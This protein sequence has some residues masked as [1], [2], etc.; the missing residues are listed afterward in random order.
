[1]IASLPGILGDPE[2]R[3]YT[4]AA[5]IQNKGV[6]L[7]LNWADNINKDWGYNLNGNIAFNHNEVLELNEGEPLP[8]GSVGGQ[9]TTTLTDVGQPIGSFYLWQVDGL[10]QTDE[11]ATA[12][13]QS[14]ARAGDLRYRDQNKDG[15]IDAVDRVF[16][17]SYQPK[18]TYG[19]NGG[20]TYRT[21]DLS[22]NTYGTAGGKI[23]NGKKAAR[24]DARDNIETDVAKNRWTIENRNTNVP[25]A[26]TAELPASTYF[27]ERGD[28]FRINNL[29]IGYKLPTGSISRFGL[30]NVRVFVT[31]QNLATFTKYS[32]FT[33]ELIPVDQTDNPGTLNAGI[34]QGVYPT[35]RTWAFGLNLSF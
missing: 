17:G 34:E 25:R 1:V 15:R 31:A 27:L 13:G 22:I 26:N 11:E 33:P 28:F 6:E 16:S 35:T 19:I 7:G 32:G 23:Y 14:G 8:S 29:T 5:T 9:G 12:S 2:S 3:F 21:F 30:E 18:F 20:V 10:F 4:N 24:G